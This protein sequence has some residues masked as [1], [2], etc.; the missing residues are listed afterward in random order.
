MRKLFAFITA[1]LL[2]LP[3]IPADAAQTWQQIHDRIGVQMDQVYEIYKTGNAEGAK[4]AVNDIYYGIYEKDGLE[5]AVRS[6]ISSK[7]AN[8]TEYQFYTLKKVIRAGAPQAEVEAEGAK[9]LDMIQAEVTTLETKGVESGGWAMFLQAFLILLREGIE[10]ILVLVG[11]IAY[12]GRAGHE[13]ELS[14][15]YNWAIAGII[16]SFVTAY[17]FV[18]VLDNTTTTGS[19]REI[20]EG[21]TAL[22]AVLVLLGTS[23]WMGGKSNAKAWKSYIDKQVKLTLSTGKSRAL[24]AA[25]FL[26]VYREGAE[27]ILF[28][29]ALFNNAVGD[30][31][32]IWAGFVTACVALALI[33]FL[34]QRGA[35][36]IPIGP[37]FKVTSAFMFILAV[38]FLGGGLKELQEADVI[39]TSVIEAVP[40]PSIDLLG[41]YP[42][43]ETIV[44]QIL[45][46]LAAV[47]MVSYKKRSAASEA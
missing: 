20:I 38:T 31:D 12:L 28:Y 16:M 5:S 7:S 18:E 22:F 14:T 39:S 9:L 13:K 34:M 30:V 8:L 19:G 37:F 36:R 27:V 17:L 43:Y 11:I 40:V 25:V 35:L 15:V 44:P 45:L 42:T 46:I 26:A 2:F 47:A 3:A 23:A 32:M 24:G 21:C 1:L 33:F 41:L 10:A 4:D 6:G 29:Q